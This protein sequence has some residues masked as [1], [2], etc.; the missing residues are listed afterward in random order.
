M[1]R[2]TSRIVPDDWNSVAH[3]IATLDAKLNTDS[4]PIFLSLGLTG[5]TENALMY[6]DSDGVLTSLAAATNGQLIIGSTGA[7]PS[8]VALTG[9]P[10]QI[11]VT[12]GAGSITLSTPQNIHTAATPTFAGLILTGNLDMDGNDIDDLNAINFNNNSSVLSILSSNNIGLDTNTFKIIGTGGLLGDLEVAGAITVGSD[13]GATSVLIFKTTG[14]DGVFT[15]TA[16]TDIL[17]FDKALTVGNINIDGLTISRN[18]TGSFLVLRGQPTGIPAINI[19]AGNT[20]TLNSNNP[21]SLANLTMSGDLIVEGSTELDVTNIG[22]GTNETQISAT[23]DLSFAGTAG[24]IFGHMDVPAAAVIT[25][26]TSG[27]LNPVEIKDDGTVSA[28]DGWETG[29]L[30]GTTFAVSDL[31]YITVTITGKYKVI[32]SVSPATAAGAGTEIHGGIVVD[33]VAI[34]DNGEGHAHVFNANDNI[35]ICGVGVIDCPNGYEEISL[36]IANDQNQKT[37]VEHG[38]MYIQLIAGT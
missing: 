17:T 10:N 23:G 33:D 4:S 9:T 12:P 29:E 14:D 26:D 36:W 5:L 31:H 21:I 34:R 20:I 6:A 1:G 3:A 37:V 15:Y 13:A 16:A 24:L 38:N 28:D 32:W 18:D 22:D 30:N 2:L 27:T 35:N 8:V 25:V 19:G 11:I 7:A